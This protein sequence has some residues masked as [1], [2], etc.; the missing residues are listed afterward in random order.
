MGR[1][2]PRRLTWTLLRGC[3]EPSATS[4]KKCG[5]FLLNGDG[6]LFRSAETAIL[7][8]EEFG[9]LRCA[10]GKLKNPDQATVQ[11]VTSKTFLL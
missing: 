6:F 11:G 1:M 2:A 8:A 3:A 5:D 7:N 9:N 10:D 4:R